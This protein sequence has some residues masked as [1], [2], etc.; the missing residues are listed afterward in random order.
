M[1]KHLTIKHLSGYLPYRLKV[2]VEDYKCDYV[3]LEFDEVVGFCQWDK[4]GLL[5]SVLTD[6]GAKPSIE[7]V[8]PILRPLSELTDQDTIA[9]Y[10]LDSVILELIIIS[11]WTKELIQ[12]LKFNNKFKLHQFEYLFSKHYDI[13]GLIELGSAIDINTLK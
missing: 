8:K 3:G 9:F 13:Y 10:D 4:S 2:M 6:G 1:G 5:W 7:R 11:E 12:E